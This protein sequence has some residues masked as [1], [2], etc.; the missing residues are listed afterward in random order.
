MKCLL[1]RGRNEKCTVTFQYTE[2]VYWIKLLKPNLNMHLH[3][4][5]QLKLEKMSLI[6]RTTTTWNKSIRISTQLFSTP[7]SF[8]SCRGTSICWDFDLKNAWL[9]VRIWS[10]QVF[11]CCYLIDTHS[12]TRSYSK[13][14]EDWSSRTRRNQW[15]KY[16]L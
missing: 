12:T 4:R 2:K 5:I 7:P 16:H 13:T 8:V 3:Q 9:Y 10:S 14:E 6:H 11:L 15:L 1:K